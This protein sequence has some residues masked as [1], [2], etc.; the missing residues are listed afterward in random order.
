M[1][2]R[3]FDIV[4]SSLSLGKHLFTF[5]LN[6]EFF[7]FFEYTDHKKLKATVAVALTKHNTFLELEFKLKGKV[8]VIC[9]RTGE[10]FLQKIKDSFNLLV[11]FG[12]EYNADDDERLILPQGEFKLNI[13]QYLFELIVL[14]IPQKNLHP[15]VLSGKIDP[16]F[17]V[18]EEPDFKVEEEEENDPRWDKLKDLLN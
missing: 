4:F 11:K 9:D 13:A 14:A 17:I 5:E 12:D 2:K 18:E 1:H 7:E 15:D 10:P 6:D 3:D 8:E 16:E